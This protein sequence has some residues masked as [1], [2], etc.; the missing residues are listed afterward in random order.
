MKSFSLTL[1]ALM[2]LLN[3][4]GV[5]RGDFV[6]SVDPDTL[7][8]NGPGLHSVN[9]MITH[10]GFGFSTLSG[11]TIRFG[12]PEDASLGELP[13][14]VRAVAAV[15]G[16]VQG[17]LFD[18]NLTTNT[19]A[20]SSLFAGNFEVGDSQTKRLFT[21]SFE[22]GDAPSYVIGVDFQSAQ[23]GLLGAEDISHE[24]GATN[25]PTTD[26]T[27]QLN[28]LSAIPEPGCGVFLISMLTTVCIRRRKRCC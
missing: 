7:A 13:M 6:L 17:E 28:N 8:F 11:Y 24:F 3:S 21:L 20:A 18:L 27:F 10:D 15:N 23:R 1:F 5:V 19:V 14:G 9:M 2:L 4:A 16:L 26:F 25:S 22:L 12:S